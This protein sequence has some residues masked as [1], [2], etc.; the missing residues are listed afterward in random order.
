MTIIAVALAL[1]TSAGPSPPPVWVTRADGQSPGAPY[2]G[3]IGD[4]TGSQLAVAVAGR[5]RQRDVGVAVATVGGCQ[6]TDVALTY[7]NPTYLSAHRNCVQDAPEKQRDLTALYHPKVVIWSDIMEWSDIEAEHGRTV[8]AG[9]GEWQTRISASWDRL[10]GRLG[11]A[12]VV[13]VLPTWWTGAPA[14]F[15]PWFSVRRQ[16]ELFQSW[17]GRHTDRVTV[18]DLAPVLCPAGPPCPDTVGGVRLRTDQVH[19]TPEGARRAVDRIFDD[20]ADLKT[21]HGPAV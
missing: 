6:P 15:P 12:R 21:L 5:L 18:V 17:A 3:V 4:S 13:L 1:V 8:V 11:E 9:S 16:R 10:L 20:V 14:A 2:V 19:F 7:Q